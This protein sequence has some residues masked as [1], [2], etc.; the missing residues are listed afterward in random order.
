MGDSFLNS[1]KH[2]DAYRGA[3]VL[4]TEY[5]FAVEK[6]IIN[7]ELEDEQNKMKNLEKQMNKLVKENKN[8]HKE[9]ENA[10][11]KI[12]KA[13]IN[14]EQ[15]EIDQTNKTA[16]IEAQM[17]LLNEI[18]TRLNNVGKKKVKKVV[19]KEEMKEEKKEEEN[20]DEGGQ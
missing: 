6:Y 2:N 15:N 9:I 11:E 16:E 10:Q 20:E 1:E 17:V 3:E 8:Y 5:G 4:L 19:E 13:E 7:K 12:R 18:E 14:I